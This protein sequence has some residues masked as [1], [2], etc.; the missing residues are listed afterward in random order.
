M[1]APVT[2]VTR[3]SQFAKRRLLTALSVVKMI[4]TALSSNYLLLLC[5]AKSLTIKPA[6]QQRALSCSQGPPGSSL[7]RIF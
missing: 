4:S 2:R 3:L 7:A 5:G 1:A 6:F